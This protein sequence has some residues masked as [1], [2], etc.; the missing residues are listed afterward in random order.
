M[1]NFFSREVKV[2]IMAITAISVLYIGLN[3]LKGISSKLFFEKCPNA[4]KRYPK[5][6]LWSP[7]KY[8]ASMGFVQIDV[9]NEYIKNQ[10]KHHGTVWIMEN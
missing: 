9:V 5:G 3:F 8:A 6:H 1:K 10:D 4:R 2:G 7:G